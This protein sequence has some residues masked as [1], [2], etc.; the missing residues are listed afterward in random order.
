M[1]EDRPLA[2]LRSLLHPLRATFGEIALLSFYVNLLALAVPVFALQVYDRVI[3]QHGLSTLQALVVGMAAAV[4]F[5]F[6]MRQ[7]RARILQTVALRL[8]VAVGRQLFEKFVS[9]PLPVLENRASGH[10]LALFRDVEAVRNT[11]SGASA[12]LVCD[13]PFVLLFLA[14][15]FVVAAPAAWV[16]VLVL[17][18]FLLVAWRSGRT[19]TE[20]SR[21]EREQ[22]RSRDELVTEMIAA[23]S[24][25]KALGLEQAIRPLWEERHARTIEQAIVRGAQADGHANLSQTLMI[26]T[27]VTM[28]TVGALAILEQ[29]LTIGALIAANMLSSRLLGPLNQLVGQWRA[30]TAFRQ[31]A[32]RLGQT[33]ALASERAK[34]A[35]DGL[36]PKGRVTLEAISFGYAS[37][38][39]PAVAALSLDLGPGGLH[40]VVGANGSGKSTVL[41]L[42]QGLYPP[43]DGRV[44][45][46]AADIAQ[47]GRAEIARWIGYVPQECVLLAGTIRDNIAHRL[48]DADDAEIIRAARAAGAHGFVVDLPDGYA[49]PVGEAGGRLSAGQRQRLAIARA[50]LG[51]PPVLLMDEPSSN[52]DREAEA[53]LRASLLAMSR[54]HTVIVVSHALA[55]LS[56]CDSIT[57]LDGGRLVI[58]GPPRA[59]LGRL[60]GTTDTLHA[61]S[62]PR[63]GG[64]RPREPAPA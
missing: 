10:W 17:P 15:I 26:V 2:W 19:M 47:F 29:Q 16:L 37:T 21:C 53:A 31:A 20:A 14:L 45:L 7:S 4:A 54:E 44:L 41:K 3:F 52:L 56:A 27:S 62:A 59:V 12:V 24:T 9:L 30:Y 51:M 36:Q 48:P 50:L 49:T 6:V 13:L 58:T 60:C 33:F 38:I 63:G 42:M 23:R 43:A 46:D 64:S 22:A 25:I 34:G 55:L 18:A 40:A 1:S 28:T 11:L 5:D 61:A 57:V 39:R 32:E 35:I 8:D